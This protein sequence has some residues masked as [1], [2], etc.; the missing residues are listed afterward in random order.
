MYVYY[1]ERN[2]FSFTTNSEVKYPTLPEPGGKRDNNADFAY[3]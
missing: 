1:D 2:S 3:S